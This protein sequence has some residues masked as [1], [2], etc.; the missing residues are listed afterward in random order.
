M[1]FSPPFDACISNN[2][3]PNDLKLK[4]RVALD[5]SHRC[6]SF[7]RCG[8]RI[9]AVLFRHL[10]QRATKVGFVVVGLPSR[11]NLD[12]VAPMAYKSRV[13]LSPGWVVDVVNRIL[14]DCA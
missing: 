5:V 1:N 4:N 10:A 8:C 7:H 12:N 14:I 3:Q 2:I 13:T 11:I 6:C 9:G